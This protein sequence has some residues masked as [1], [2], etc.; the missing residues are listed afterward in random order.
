MLLIELL[1]IVLLLGFAANGFRAGVVEGLGRFVG[2][3]VGFWAAKTFAAIPVTILG[4]FLPLSWAYAASF[5][6]LFLIANHL[7][8]FLFKAVDRIFGVLTNL[9]LLKQINEVAGL[10]L[11]L[12]EGI[13]VIGGVSYLLRHLSLNGGFTSLIV[14]LKTVQAIETVFTTILGFLL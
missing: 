12:L 3:L 11:G 10:V 6:L 1:V 4:L 14:E 7:V 9:P 13:V 8:G 2:A 5:L